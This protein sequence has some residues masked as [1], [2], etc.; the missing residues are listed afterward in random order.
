MSM[1]QRADT[2]EPKLKK[3]SLRKAAIHGGLAGAA[4]FVAK[5]SAEGL[6]QHIQDQLQ[7]DPQSIT[8]NIG[9]D[10]LSQSAKS[11]HQAARQ[12]FVGS[13]ARRTRPESVAR[14]TPLSP[15]QSS[16]PITDATRGALS[17]A[18]FGILD[19]EKRKNWANTKKGL[20]LLAGLSTL[21]SACGPSAMPTTTEVAP[22]SFEF[23]KSGVMDLINARGAAFPNGSLSNPSCDTDK[24]GF[25]TF[26]FIDVKT[27]KT[28]EVALCTADL[29]A[30]GTKAKVS[31]LV[32]DTGEIFTPSRPSIDVTGDQLTAQLYELKP[33]N[34]LSQDGGF[35]F[36]ATREFGKAADMLW[37]Q[38]DGVTYQV[39]PKADV[40]GEIPISASLDL[41]GGPN[42]LDLM[43]VA[44]TAVATGVD[45][46]TPVPTEKLPATV[47]ATATEAVPQNGDTKIVLENGKPIEYK[48]NGEVD[49]WETSH[50]IL[51]TLNGGV[52]LID[53]SADGYNKSIPFILNAK[54]GQTV[55]WIQHIDIGDK[56]FSTSPTFSRLFYTRLLEKFYNKN[57]LRVSDDDY[58]KFRDDFN[59]GKISIPYTA[60][61]GTPA[62]WK[63]SSGVRET[64][65]SWED[66]DPK[67]D[68]RFKEWSIVGNDIVEKT[69]GDYRS[70]RI[71]GP[72]Q[73]VII[74]TASKK[75]VS[76]MT[77]VEKSTLLFAQLTELTDPAPGSVGANAFVKD[78]I[79]PVGSG[80][81]YIAITTK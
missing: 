41:G 81:G 54:E 21:L 35:A 57:I 39:N 18:G 45:T 37:L 3:F 11:E 77:D 50:V 49:V 79:T 69:D 42:V 36:G 30:A 29:T 47:T 25:N 4:I 51:P 70:M 33:D 17:V 9:E 44:L 5:P 60:T 58:W 48:F 40:Q 65:V 63:L 46:K 66:A 10:S 1:E 26:S 6:I 31:L 76:T 20:L 74:I 28:K 13:S 2:Q 27:N 32:F 61:D 16:V 75:E 12:I 19:S 15:E 43:N 71:E 73:S 52:P 23:T 24:G 14:T 38:A 67:K 8:F 78:I 55:P 34:K 80:N 7:R 68:P 72:N 53:Q 56:S 59:A 62:I 64:I 22:I